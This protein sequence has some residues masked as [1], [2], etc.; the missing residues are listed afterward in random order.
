[1]STEHKSKGASLGRR[2]AAYWLEDWSPSI[3][4]EWWVVLGLWVPAV[5]M[6]LAGIAAAIAEG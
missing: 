2:F 1:M 4:R 5:L 3:L 6:L